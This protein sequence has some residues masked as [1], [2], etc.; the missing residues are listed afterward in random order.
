[1]R[2]VARYRLILLL[3]VLPLTGCLFRSHKVQTRI[4]S[5]NLKT[6]NQQELIDEVNTT[7]QQIKTLNATVDIAASVGGAKKGKVTEYQEIRGYIL[8]RQP[9]ML[10]MIGLM[11][12]VR[13]RAF[14]MVSNGQNF[15]LWI[16]AKGKFYVGRNDVVKPGASALESLRPQII[17]NALLL[18]DINAKEDIAVLESGM[19]RVLDPKSHNEVQQPDYRLDIVTR[20]PKGWYLA[21]KIFFDRVDL[22]PRR[23]EVFDPEGDVAS[24][25]TYDRWEQHGNIWYPNVIELWRPKE[26]YKITLGI[27]K[28]AVNEP[29][30]DDQ[31]ALA[32]PPG[33]QVIRLD[34][35][36]TSGGNGG[37]KPSQ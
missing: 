20:G 15:E 28:L 13:S 11:P 29:L 1:M 25:I 8:V 10:H 35:T 12:V 2:N 34:N 23:Q 6:A 21:R 9:N 7:A 3:L 17:Y 24:D 26:E 4:S 5:A 19:Q 32:Q 16:P 27:V 14:D 33:V 31:F 36:P 22:R 37:S 18:N 30:T